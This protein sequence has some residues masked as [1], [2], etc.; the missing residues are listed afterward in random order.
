MLGVSESIVDQDEEAQWTHLGVL[1][2]SISQV[3]K[4]GDT[5]LITDSYRRTLRKSASH[6]T[7]LG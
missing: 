7:R 4:G 1:G 5:V 6:A 3:L 2:V